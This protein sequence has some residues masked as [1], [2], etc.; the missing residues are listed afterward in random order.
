MWYLIL[1][2]VF[3]KIWV[4]KG[5]SS[6]R[7]VVLCTQPLTLSEVM[8]NLSYDL[9][10]YLNITEAAPY[11]SRVFV[12]NAAI[13]KMIEALPVLRGLFIFFIGNIWKVRFYTRSDDLTRF[14]R[15]HTSCYLCSSIYL[16]KHR[17]SILV[18]LW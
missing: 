4:D 13:T 16:Y 18:M 9:W 1:V 15:R 3:H 11:C 2:Y 12:F 17:K 5:V 14:C 8:N 10:H 7:H 6:V